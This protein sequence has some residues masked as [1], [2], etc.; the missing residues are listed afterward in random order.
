MSYDDSDQSPV[1][2]FCV[3][4]IGDENRSDHFIEPIAVGRS[5]GR[6]SIRQ[7]GCLKSNWDVLRA[8]SVPERA[9]SDLCGDL[10]GQCCGHIERE[11]LGPA[12][13]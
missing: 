11:L 8:Q 2:G 13:R 1:P 5:C 9:W 4:W 7:E 12:P 10:R 3:S 6:T